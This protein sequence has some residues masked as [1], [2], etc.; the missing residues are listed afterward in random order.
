M[1][2]MEP[3]DTSRAYKLTGGAR[4]IRG[5]QRIGIAI[6]CLVA[7]AGLGYSVIIGLEQR[8]T[9]Q[10]KYTQ[11][12][13]IVDMQRIGGRLAMSDLRPFD[14]DLDKSGCV[15]P[16][17][18]ET[19]PTIAG[20]AKTKPPVLEGFIEPVYIGALISGAVGG[21]IYC[22]FW[23]LGWVCAGFTKD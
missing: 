20:I 2:G 15:G 21:V 13:C 10:R 6:G 17:Y 4:F 12:K 8:D 5:F 9:A 14:V 3:Y 1:M 22:A 18:T 19:I 23:L 11:A 16:L 7:L